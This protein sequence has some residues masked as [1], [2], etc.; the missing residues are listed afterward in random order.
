MKSAFIRKI[1]SKAGASVAAALLLFLV[2]AVVG[3]VVL[4]AG[5]SASGRL[6]RAKESDIRYY[7]VSSAAEL[8]AQELCG[9]KVT[10]V[11]TKTVT[12]R[13]TCVYAVT[14][15]ADGTDS[16]VLSSSETLR[17]AT[18]GT[19]INGSVT[20]VTADVEVDENGVPTGE[21]SGASLSLEGASFLTSRAAQ[22]MFGGANCN[23]EAAMGY[24]FF[25]GGSVV[26]SFT[27]VHNTPAG[28]SAGSLTADCVCETK[29]DGTLVIKVSHG[30]GGDKFTLV[31]TL[32]PSVTET[33]E[34]G[35]PAPA[36]PVVTPTETGYTE[37]TEKIYG[38][39]VT[40]EITWGL[41]SITKE[42]AQPD[43]SH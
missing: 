42:E 25:G 38:K 19:D 33:V 36:A 5:T 10:V 30:S 39:T 11:R 3:S 37:V 14:V 16:A 34:T 26:D 43:E 20:A 2:C 7:S 1:K 29:N 12:E 22:L 6:S 27:L 13:T 23:T 8:L 17:T 18:Y 28:I 40:S 15:G 32:S 31:V 9:K 21:N 35:S 24:S 4:V 41:V